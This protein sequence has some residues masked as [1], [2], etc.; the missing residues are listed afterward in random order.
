MRIAIIAALSDNHVL[1][2][3]N[4]LPWSLPDDWRHFRR[5]TGE[6]PFITGRTSYEAEDRLLSPGRNL[7]LTRKGGSLPEANCETVPSL[8]TALERVAADP[9]TGPEGLV[10]ITGG[11]SVYREALPMAN[12][13]WLTLVHA[14]LDGDAWFP[15]MDWSNWNIKQSN[16]HAADAQHAHPFHIV[17]LQRKAPW[18]LALPANP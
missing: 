6:H 4:A 10:F 13:A 11:A 3:N 12:E 8:E 18:S 5:V 7:V 14:Q 1:G 9:Q 17:H 16:W 2:L 15:P